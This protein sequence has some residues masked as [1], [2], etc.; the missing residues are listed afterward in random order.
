MI[1]LKDIRK[2][3]KSKKGLPTDALNGINI[4][5]G[6]KGIT[7]VLGKSGSGKSTLLNILGGIDT[8][9]SGDIIVNGKSTKDFKEK[10]WD[11]YR[12][13][14][15]GF[16][17]QEYNLLDN[18]SVEDNIKLAMELQHKKCSSKEVQEVLNM[19]DLGDVL[20]R[21]P[22]EL[23]GGQKQRI[24]IARALI[25]SPEII[26]A[27][28]PTGNL[29][30]QTSE[31]IFEILKKL[32]KDKL[33]VIVSHDE[34]S[35]N[36]YADRIIRISDGVIEN[37]TNN[38]EI[39]ENNNFKLITANLP[40]IY[41]LKMGLGNLFH[42]KIRLLFSVTLITA[43]LICFGLMLSVL[44]S[45]PA[46]EVDRL[47]KEIGPAE[48][49]IVKYTKEMDFDTYLDDILLSNSA[50]PNPMLDPTDE[51]LQEVRNK[52]GMDFYGVYAFDV[53]ESL[54]A[55]QFSKSYTAKDSMYNYYGSLSLMRLSFVDSNNT[56]LDKNNLIGR[57]PEK[58]DEIVVST[59]LADLFSYYGV[60][61]KSNIN[62]KEY[63]VYKPK[64][65]QALVSS[66]RYLKFGDLYSFKVVGVLSYPE[67]T[68][69]YAL[70]KK[71]K[72][73]AYWDMDYGENPTLEN[74]YNEFYN[75][76]YKIFNKVYVNSSFIDKFKSIENNI[77]NKENELIDNDNYY[78]AEKIAYI[79]DE[80]NIYN[81]DGLTTIKDL[82]ENEIVINTALLD[83]LTDYEFSEK[84]EEAM[85]NTEIEFDK[86]EFIINYIKN[87]N[88]IGKKVKS[89]VVDNKIRNDETKYKEYEI[90][91]VYFDDIDVSIAYYNKNVMDKLIVKLFSLS[92]ISYWIT[93]LD[94]YKKILEYY[95]I[96]DA[97]I[98]S[99]SP[100]SNTIKAS[101]SI[102]K[103]FKLL[104]KYGSIFFL[105][106]AIVLFMS[107]MSTS[108]SFRK[109][110][111]GILRGIGCR[112]IDVMQMFIYESIVLILIC[113]GLSF[114]IIPYLEN[115]IN[116][117]TLDTFIKVKVLDFGL[118]QKLEV[119]G[120]MLGIAIVSSILP[121]RKLTKM[122]PIDTILGK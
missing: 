7:F 63:S 16:V 54:N 34:E 81:N 62:D 24:A 105:V 56:L 76:D 95:P 86:D 28:E 32:S 3:Y 19:V 77:A 29:D 13:T 27:D 72:I 45:D 38:E 70:F 89:S 97:I 40:F 36:K 120:I 99:E 83:V 48:V 71:T 100:Y 90:I 25:K 33:V 106:F 96:E 88:I 73:S 87:K 78:E 10:D 41:S 101:F 15:I 57:L 42:K 12:N 65:Y 18:Y 113:V 35:A 94:D 58:D 37:D 118:Y 69:K 23:S 46:K 79:K 91:G 9:T 114:I 39:K 121:I 1:E 43:C 52:T 102:S 20:K 66:E 59:Y 92:S 47:F 17:F 108:I 103:I 115:I 8:Y 11:S 5:L 14:Y 44:N 110:E 21:K 55:F 31:Q 75:I 80:I 68:K 50:D 111:I 22:N 119:I 74:L 61:G 82:K 49:D 67:L 2:T 122:K 60:L 93:T 6:E 4:K 64:T 85:L 98:V 109:K 84:L 30:S 107:F 117:Y 51:L 104:G 116:N 26:L 53:T 112:S